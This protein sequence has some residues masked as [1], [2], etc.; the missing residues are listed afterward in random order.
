MSTCPHKV[1]SMLASDDGNCVQ[2][3]CQACGEVL[4]QQVLVEADDEMVDDF[5][6][7]QQLFAD[8]TPMPFEMNSQQVFVLVGQL[9]LA[10]RHPRNCGPASVMARGLAEVLGDMLTDLYPAVGQVIAAGWDENAEGF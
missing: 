8:P 10:L 2:A 3:I 5:E 6:A 4:R 9:Q 7:V 1:V